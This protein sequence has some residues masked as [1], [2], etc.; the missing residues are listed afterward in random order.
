MLHDVLQLMATTPSSEACIQALLQRTPQITGAASAYFLML[1]EPHLNVAIGS[2]PPDET[3]ISLTK[4]LGAGIHF[5][6]KL[7][8]GHKSEGWLFAPIQIDQRPAGFLWLACPSTYQPDQAATQDL[9]ALVHALEITAAAAHLRER[10]EQSQRLLSSVLN[11][12]ADPLL[13]L[14]DNKTVLL[15]NPAAQDVFQTNT[16]QAAG[17][18]VGEMLRVEALLNLIDNPSATLDEWV[19]ET[20]QTF[21]PRVEVVYDSDNRPIGQIL[22]LRDVTR[23]KRLNRNQSEFVR[24]VTHDLRSP[25]TSMQGF[26]SMMSMAGELNEKQKHFVD[27]ILAGITQIT[28]LVENIQDAGRY[29]PE[30][31]FYEMSRSQLDLTEMVD[32]IVENHL[33]PAEKQEL[34]ISVDKGQDVPIVY[35]DQHM[36]ERAITNLVDN[37]IKYTPNGGKITV[38]VYRRDDNV[39]VAVKDTGLGINPEQQKHLFERH[40]R[41]ARQEFKRIKGSGLGLFIV[42]SVA[43]RHGGEAWVESA[44]GQGST[45]L[46]RIPLS[47][48]NLTGAAQVS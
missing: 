24:I 9:A 17:K 33:V 8:D 43:R 7:S 19:S 10:D 21:M 26:A 3:L 12:I 31:G 34:S 47:E 4:T 23:F 11:S 28:G 38:G 20:D 15:M 27:R 35:A 39:V 18:S 41:I 48:T 25:L 22:A 32:R 37:A 36:L 5:N 29:D 46:I 45:F 6:P 13:V 14:D 30:T 16:S 2:V 1:V 40:Q 44:E 42:R